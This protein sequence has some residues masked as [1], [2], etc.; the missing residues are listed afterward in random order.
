[1]SNEAST[2][3][4]QAGREEIWGKYSVE[5]GYRQ[6]IVIDETND[7]VVIFGRVVNTSKSGVSGALL[8][9]S[10]CMEDGSEIP[11][12]YS[13]SDNDGSYMFSF[14]KPQVPVLKYVLRTNGQTGAL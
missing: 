5:G 1:M 3:D 7:S 13:L 8:Y 11:L 12:A 4:I 2:K 9:V 14:N 6:D 10:A